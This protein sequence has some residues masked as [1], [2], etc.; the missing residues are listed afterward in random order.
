VYICIVANSHPWVPPDKIGDTLHG[1]VR[2]TLQFC[3]DVIYQVISFIGNAT[4]FPNIIDCQKCL[5]YG[6][7]VG[8]HHLQ[9]FCQLFNM[10][11]L[12]FFTIRDHKIRSNFQDRFD[13]GILRSAYN[14]YLLN[15]F[16]RMYTK[17][18]SAHQ[19]VSDSKIK[20]QFRK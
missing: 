7:N 18:G 5:F 12:I 15:L 1:F 3:P 19:A 14:W 4:S 11:F 6:A 10:F 16:F 20:E 9:R 2:N 17:T 8:Y 13:T